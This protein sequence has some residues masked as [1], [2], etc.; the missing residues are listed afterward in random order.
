MKQKLEDSSARPSPENAA[1]AVASVPRGR[2][3][4]LH[5]L[6]FKLTAGTLVVVLAFIWGITLYAIANQRAK[7]EAVEQEQQFASVRYMAADLDHKLRFRLDG[8]AREAARLDVRR[9]DDPAYLQD[10]LEQRY[11]FQKEFSGGIS[12][13]GMD[14]RNVAD[15]PVVPGRKGTYFGDRGYFTQAVATRR[16]YIDQPIMGRALQRPVLAM[17]APVMDR[18]GVVRAVMTG[19]IDLTAPDF[20]GL[21]TDASLLG[22]SE[23]YIVSLEHEVFVASTD[24]SRVMTALPPPGGSEIIDQLRA[25]FEGSMVSRSS[26]GIQKLYSAKR[27]PTTGWVA[28]LGLP[29]DIAFQPA[30]FLERLLLGSAV[31][32]TF[33]AALVVV[34]LSRRL[35]RPLR[36]ASDQLDA[37]SSGREP[38]RQLSEEGDSEVRSLLASFNRLTGYLQEEQADLLRYRR[39]LEDLV[40]QRTGE[41]TAAKE[42]AEAANQA[43]SAF[44]ANMSH[45]IRTPMNA[46][47]GMTE[48]CLATRPEARLG[49]YLEKIKVSSESLL[50]VI[51]D[52]LDFSKIEA[53]KLDIVAEPFNLAGVFD[54]LKSMLAVRAQTKGLELALP[55]EGIPRQTLLG[56][57]MR[58]TQVLV[59]LVGN[60]IKFSSRGR[61]LVTVAEG[62]RDGGRLEL[63][64]S[65]SDQGI[66]I[67]PEEQEQL[68]LPFS[69]ADTSTTRRYGGTGL[70]LAICRR[71]IDLMG[72]RI[73]VESVPGKGSTFHFT[74]AFDITDAPP[75]PDPARGLQA[76]SRDVVAGLQG[77]DILVVEDTELNQEVMCD[78]LKQ[79]GLKVRLAA[80]GEEA[81]RAVAEARPDCVLMDCH[82][83][84]MDGFETTRRLRADQRY[85]DLPIIALTANALS[86][87]RERC[88]AA[89]M[90][91]FLA[92]PVDVADLLAVLARWV[93]V[94][95]PA[96]SQPP[97][98]PP[99][100][101]SGLP[102]LPGLDTAIGLRYLGGRVPSYIRLLR[103]F[104]ETRASGF[105]AGFREALL[106][107]NWDTAHRLAH[108]LKGTSRTLGAVRLGD[109]AV[110]LER[111]VEE[112]SQALD[113][114]LAAV[115]LE[116]DRVLHGLERLEDLERPAATPIPE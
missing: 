89:G 57:R 97:T 115:S 38:I 79:A 51:D 76:A 92:K 14:G 64:F 43:K 27:V 105:D 20:L 52:I 107:G 69:Q 44:L 65:V 75:A 35:L 68:F 10:F 40:A 77:A 25:G 88:L 66:G 18:S 98:P 46:I 113:S 41:L 93:T 37:M 7:L 94:R 56:D 114:R 72:G 45:E 91:G 4:A 109:L 16:P 33:L 90:N 95:P 59:N 54:G 99:P 13:I 21:A 8:L 60:A 84:V 49:N 67:S 61:V 34:W 5:S 87:D 85:R 96:A 80:D 116:L 48:L 9:L 70:G 36:Q 86:G 73:W 17:S 81:L 31:A 112:R 63:H 22:K 53:G 26:R 1:E 30:H 108:S 82:M 74:V 6:R 50:R 62:V 103:L 111:A 78:L 83:P 55:M 101:D 42:A 24:K 39:H 2:A 71:L 3:S 58:L 28:L 11:L 100:P 29:S 47:M 19:I 23:L 104:R 32:A 110:E 102:D 15:Y 12:I 106:A